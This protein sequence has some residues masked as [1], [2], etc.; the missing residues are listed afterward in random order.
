[1]KKLL[2]SLILVF[3]FS[4]CEGQS[5]VWGRQGTASLG[6][7][8]NWAIGTDRKGN[9]YISGQYQYTNVFGGDSIMGGTNYLV[10]YNCNGKVRWAKTDTSNKVPTGWSD[11][12]TTDNWGNVYLAGTFNDTV[13]FDSIEL[14][15]RQSG[16]NNQLFI[17]KYDSNGKVLWAKQTTNGVTNGFSSLTGFTMATDKMG[18]VYFTGSIIDSMYFDSTHYINGSANGVIFVAKYNKN[19]D[20]SWVKQNKCF[21]FVATGYGLEMDDSDYI[22]A[23]GYG[24]DTIAFDNKKV[25]ANGTAVVK[26]DTG[27]NVKWVYTFDEQ[28]KKRVYAECMGVDRDG[29]IYLS[30]EFIDTL[31]FGND[32]L[33]VSNGQYFLAKL[34][35]YAQPIRIL[36]FKSLDSNTYVCYSM[37]VDSL[38][39]LYLALGDGIGYPTMKLKFGQDTL[40]LNNAYDGSVFIQTD[41]LFNF[42]CGTMNRSGG[43][44]KNEVTVDPM[45]KFV[46]F[47][48]HLETITE[49]GNDTLG[50]PFNGDQFTFVSRW[51]PCNN[52]EAYIPTQEQISPFIRVFPNPNTGAFTLEVKNE[53]LRA[54]SVEVYNVMGQKVFTEILRSAQDD[55]LI[56]LTNQPN[57]VYLYRVIDET[58]KLFGEGKFVIEK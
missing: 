11:C 32:T 5:W 23:F 33:L 7:S 58:G 21:G 49:F 57:G 39:N 17:A 38:K 53:E 48:G 13:Y 2:L 30:G 55:N 42:V 6:Y 26:F 47:A 14:V 27:G 43:H 50:P 18:N 22:Y 19:G 41:S 37:A 44:D 15:C 24:F 40:H 36:Q 35:S 54:K 4:L 56:E 52:I 51:Q 10:K 31:F 8:D 34:N 20:L 3:G 25:F 1:L 46:Y 9:V 29:G 28:Q 45:G 16:V 12:V